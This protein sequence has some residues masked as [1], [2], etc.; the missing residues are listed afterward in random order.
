MIGGKLA[1]R[2]VAGNRKGKFSRLAIPD[3]GLVWENVA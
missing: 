3:A 2:S 1:T